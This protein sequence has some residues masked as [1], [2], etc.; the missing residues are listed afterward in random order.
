MTLA[1]SQEFLNRTQ[2]YKKPLKEEAK[3]YSIKTQNLYLTKDTI[4]EK[5]RRIIKEMFLTNVSNGGLIS[6]IYNNS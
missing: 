2:R 3:M 6:R 1:L 5:I 4:K